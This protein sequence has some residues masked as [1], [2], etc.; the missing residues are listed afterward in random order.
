LIDSKSARSWTLLADVR[1]AKGRKKE[2]LE[3]I[4]KAAQITTD[5]PAVLRTKGILLAET[6][7]TPDA[8]SL[9]AAAVQRF[10]RD[11]ELRA[12]YGFVLLRDR[13]L[14]EAQREFETAL[15]IDPTIWLPTIISE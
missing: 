3:A 13:K 1:A 12:G 11:A 4:Q 10:P 6:G 7:S 2:A 9:L 5:D 14:D 15:S 8:L